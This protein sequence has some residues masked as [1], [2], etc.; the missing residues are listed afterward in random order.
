LFLEKLAYVLEFFG[1]AVHLFS[2]WMYGLLEVLEDFANNP[3]LALLRGRESFKAGMDLFEKN[4]PMATALQGN[5]VSRSTVTNNNHIDAR[6]DMREQLEPDR[7]AFAV[8]QKL[9]KLA[10]NA[11]QGRGNAHGAAFANALVAGDN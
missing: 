7:I 1:T 11:T 2:G 4:Y 8:T 9:K 6:F 10:I 5:P 3:S